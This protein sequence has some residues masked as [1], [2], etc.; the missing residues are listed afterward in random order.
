MMNERIFLLGQE[1]IMKKNTK[2]MG[3]AYDVL[4]T[5]GRDGKRKDHFS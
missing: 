4:E 1:R 5:K 3:Q 2:L